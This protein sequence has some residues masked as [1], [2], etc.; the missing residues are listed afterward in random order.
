MYHISALVG[1]V[2]VTGNF[3]KC[4]KST[5]GEQEMG[6]CKT[7][8]PR[9]PRVRVLVI[10]KKIGVFYRKFPLPDM[11]VLEILANVQKRAKIVK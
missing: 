5:P 10:H 7:G 1:R 9:V 3:H 4:T 2:F 6:D 8:E 11:A